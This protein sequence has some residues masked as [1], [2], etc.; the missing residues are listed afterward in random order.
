MALAPLRLTVR[1]S[2]ALTGALLVLVLAFYT[3]N[4]LLFLVAFFLIGLVLSSLL[5]FVSATRGFAPE[6]FQ[7]GRVEC[8]SLVKVGGTG[9]VSVRL[10]SELPRGFYAEVRD[11][12]SDRLRRLEGSDR[13]LTWWAPEESLQLAYV[14]SPDLRG[15]L[16]VGPTVLIAHDT[17]GLAFK[18]VTF[19]DPWSIEA[20]VQ[21][22]SVPIGHPVRLPSNVVGQTSLP[23]R[24][25]GSEFHAL[26]AYEATDEFRHIA[27]SRSTQGQLYVREYDRESQQD[28]LVLID[29][30]RGMATGTGYENALEDAIAAAARALRAT[31]D[32]GG[33]GGVVLFGEDVRRFVPAGRG[34]DHEFETLRALTDAE[35]EAKPSSL[36][37]AL[38]FL[39]AQL[40]RPTSLLLF[41][42][43]GDEPAKL[44][45]EAAA[46]RYAGHRLY[47]LVPDVA[48]MYPELPDV[49]Q[50][51]AFRAIV[52]P[53][54][55]RA[56][57]LTGALAQ[58]GASVALFGRDGAADTVAR[59]FTPDPR[60]PGGA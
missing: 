53:G 1:G 44:T 57:A 60:L 16:D 29:V 34:S 26:R 30:G 10:T 56:R 35:V 52:Q 5:T 7:V 37:T 59:L 15:L 51:D 17:L 39:R 27:W 43:P 23:A 28:L 20:L 4:V 55:R 21:P 42:A 22:P 38:R 24:G 33:R 3:T 47:A 58:G 40:R 50:Q 13:L 6:A 8:S 9:L 32:E 25:A 12:H 2:G 18:S 11:P 36:A 31:F 46:L 14:V 19:D 49:S 45:P 41:T 48:A 54:I